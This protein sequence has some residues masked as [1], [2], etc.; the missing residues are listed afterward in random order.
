MK[1]WATISL[2]V[3]LAM[4]AMAC[5][6]DEGKQTS[7][8]TLPSE[9]DSAEAT[10]QE[11]TTT[12]ESIE[13]SDE[14]ESVSEE[15]ET[16]EAS[17]SAEARGPQNEKEAMLQSYFEGLIAA[18]EEAV[19]ACLKPIG[20]V[21]P[22]NYMD[23]IQGIGETPV[24]KVFELKPQS[25]EVYEAENPTKLDFYEVVLYADANKSEE[26]YRGTLFEDKVSEDGYVTIGLTDT[27]MELPYYTQLLLNDAV[28]EPT[29]QDFDDDYFIHDVAIEEL[30][31]GD[32]TLSFGDSYIVY[33]N[34]D[35]EI[36]RSSGRP[37]L[38][39]KGTAEGEAILLKPELETLIVKEVNELLP[40]MFEAF[41][42]GT[43][44][45]E[46]LKGF[47]YSDEVKAIILKEFQEQNGMK[48]PL[49][50]G[51]RVYTP[52]TEESRTDFTPLSAELAK[53]I[54]HYAAYK[55]DGS[56]FLVSYEY[57]FVT[58][59]QFELTNTIQLHYS[60]LSGKIELL[61]I[62]ITPKSP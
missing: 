4:T 34:F 23:K 62:E 50:K 26:I 58:D 24:D 18:D 39:T 10:S 3:L 28:I 12:T 27:A 25:V 29:I 8:S 55:A 15:E 54:E 19:L 33:D 16:T 48:I 52:I 53:E 56:S 30:Y 5:N 61:G 31:S 49:M 32:Y 20:E 35:M 22:R 41:N 40:P 47:E 46:T 6:K 42:K 45:E 17:E 36:T 60:Y 14:S 9:M 13:S 11:T 43:L 57:L 2:A 7:E 38:K 37:I 59:G 1:K 44:N 21:Q 51:E